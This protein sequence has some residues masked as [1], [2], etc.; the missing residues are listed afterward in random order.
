MVDGLIRSLSLIVSLD[1]D[2]LS[3]ILLSLQVSGTAL[4]MATLLGG[5]LGIAVGLKEFPGRRLITNVLNTFMGLPPVVVGLLV[6]LLLSRSGPLGF[7]GLLYSPTAMIIAQTILAVPIVAALSISAV[8]G[9]SPAIRDTAVSLGASRWQAARVVIHDARF[10]IMAAIIAGLGRVMAEVG[11]VMMVGGNIAGH[12][13]VM[14]TAIA[15]D[16]SK[17]EFELAIALG[18]VLITLSF[19]LNFV[20][21]RLQGQIRNP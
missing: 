13:R 17:G 10:A 14:T 3:I 9:V 19:M 2:L 18:I 6:Y 21:N 20:L 8:S 12:T 1:R 7:M 16:T 4:L 11:A 5:S 15:M